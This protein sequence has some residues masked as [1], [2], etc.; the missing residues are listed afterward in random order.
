MIFDFMKRSDIDFVDADNS[1][2]HIPELA[3]KRARDVEPFF[4]QA[5]K[6]KF[7]EYKFAA[8]PGMLDFARIGYIVPAWGPLK[9]KGNSA[10]TITLNTPPAEIR[11]NKN[12]SFMP[13]LKFNE[14]IIDGLFT[15]QDNVDLAVYNFPSPWRVRCRKGLSIIVMPAFYHFKHIQSIQVIPGIVD[16]STGFQTINFIA[17][18]NKET[19]IHIEP[20]E[21]LIHIIPIPTDVITATYGKEHDYKIK[22]ID[23]SNNPFKSYKQWYAK[24]NKLNKKFKLINRNKEKYE[25]FN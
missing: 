10:G 9:I 21:P 8:C 13:A 24:Y 4:K 20:G 11:I 16:F 12:A 17:V 18:V 7:G 6:D 19:E 23:N 2:A 14:D 1:T 15:T 3:I 25:I 22:S 5:Q